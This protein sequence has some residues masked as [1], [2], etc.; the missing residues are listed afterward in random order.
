MAQR[1]RVDKEK[2]VKLIR[3][4]KRGKSPFPFARRFLLNEL[5][6]WEKVD[7]FKR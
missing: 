6:R 2:L 3:E 4:K 1:R 5:H 7:F